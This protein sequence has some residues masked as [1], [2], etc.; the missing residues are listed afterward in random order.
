MEELPVSNDELPS[1]ESSISTKENNN[2]E[3]KE[4]DDDDSS[5]TVFNPTD[6]GTV[7]IGQDVFNLPTP[8]K[9]DVITHSNSN[10]E[11]NI[12]MPDEISLH[13]MKASRIIDSSV[14]VDSPT[15]PKHIDGSSRVM[16]DTAAPIE[17]VKDAVSKFGGIVDWKTHKLHTFQVFFFCSYAV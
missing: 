2:K 6:T 1:P 9:S 14:T 15:G 13:K 3:E 4:D 7:N 16:V 5:P 8:K 17:S 12:L 10:A 11:P